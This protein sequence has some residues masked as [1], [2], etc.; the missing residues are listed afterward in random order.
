[1]SQSNKPNIVFWILSIVAL[2]W[3]IM[4]VLNYIGQAFITDDLKALLPE[5]QRLYMESVPAWATAA[6]AFA[7]FA[8]VLG[9]LLLLLRKKIAKTFFIIS[10]LGVLVQ[11]THGF[12][13]EIK[14][15]Y[16]LGGIA[17]PILIIGFAVFL[18]W[19]SRLV[20]SKGWL[21]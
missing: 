17:M 5:N 7:V 15:V 4:G 6:F 19:Y 10:L 16:G 21:S 9:S 13:S 12:M 20:D 18:V 1:M 2:V 3:N 11:M 14:D 8:G